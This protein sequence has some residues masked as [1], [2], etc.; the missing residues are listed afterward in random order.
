MLISEFARITGLTRDTVRF[1]ARLGLLQP[2][3]N[4]NGGRH[5]YSIFSDKDIQ[6]AEVIQILQSL[7]MSLKEIAAINE[8]RRNG[9]L[10][11]ERGLEI[12]RAQLM[13]LEAKA[14]ELEMMISYV[15]A[16]IAWLKRGK[17]GRRPHFGSYVR[18]GSRINVEQTDSAVERT[19]NQPSIAQ[20]A[21]DQSH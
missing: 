2:Q 3:T 16:K 9:E 13:R 14:T 4:G 17:Q 10:T 11:C 19:I 18:R 20:L 1:Y 8:E 15:R 6:A 5:P 21:P 7:G 12:T